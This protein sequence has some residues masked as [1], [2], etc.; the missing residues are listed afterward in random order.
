MEI[1]II[2]LGRMGRNMAQR[3]VDDGHRVVVWTRTDEKVKKAAEDGAVGSDSPEDLVS[4]LDPPRV[5]WLMLPAGDVT[6][7]LMAQVV[8][9]LAEGDVLVNGA[10]AM[11]KDSMR[12]AEELSEAGIHFVDVGVSGGV[13]GYTEGY[14]M[15]VGGDPDA[16]ELVRPALESLAPA[17]DRG[18]DHVGPAGAGHFV[19]M[20]H[21]GI[22]Y[23]M[24]QAYAEGFSVMKNKEEF[25]LDV[26]QVTQIWRFGTVIRSWLLDLIADALEDDTDLDEIAPYV[27][28]SGEGRWAVQEAIDL[29]IP[30][31]VI[32]LALLSRLRSRDEESYSDR[33]LAVMRNQFGGH[34]MKTED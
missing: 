10:N 30:A 21:N 28:D 31:P 7:K 14:G 17:P 29:D 25:D 8:P 22:E 16:V 15:M 23:G 20:V 9:V 24:M 19:K 4:K 12:H 18:W 6:E 11:Y 5:V 33:L 26:H 3:L 34:E 13:W 27:E 2:G 1:G 32:T